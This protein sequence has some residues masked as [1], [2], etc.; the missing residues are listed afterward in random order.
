MKGVNTGDDI[1]LVGTPLRTG[2]LHP[3]PLPS[4][5]L[6]SGA[7]H[8]VPLPSTP[9]RSGALNPAPLPSTPLTNPQQK[10]RNSQLEKIGRVSF[11]Y[12]RYL[13]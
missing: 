2:A 7:L 9:L 11:R 4:T 12:F 1:S 5:P 3:A 10:I 13:T 6:H 8:P